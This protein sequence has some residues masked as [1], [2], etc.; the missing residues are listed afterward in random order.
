MQP[1]KYDVV[2]V[3]S[4]LGG[5]GAG[6][7]LSHWGYQTLM[8][9]K[10]DTI[11][12][13]WANYKYEGF[14]I[15]AGALAILYHGTEM[16]EIFNEVGAEAEVIRVPRVYYRIGGKDWE[17][18]AKGAIGAMFNIIE[19][20]DQERANKEGTPRT[21]DSEKVTNA[22][23]EGIQE[24][25]KIGWLT[26][27]DWLHQYTDNE[28]AH[29]MF[30]T[31]SNTI[32][33]AHSYEVQAAA[34]FSFLVKSRGFRDVSIAP[35]G[36]MANVENLA[37]VVRANGNVWINCPAKRII[38]SGGTAKGVVVEKDGSELEIASQV[39]ISNAG[40]RKTVEL[41]GAENFGE[42]YLSRM[43]VRLKP[44]PVIMC[45]IASDRPIWPESGEPA[46]LM[47]VGARRITSVVPLSNISP[48]FAP[49]GQY[50]TFCFG[51]PVSNEIHMNAE[52]EQEQCL[53]DIKEQ[54][55][56][57]EKHGKILKMIPKDIDD[58]LPEMH[59]RIGSGMPTETPIRNLYNVGDGCETY[60]YS[61]SNLAA[62]SAKPVAETIKNSIKPGKA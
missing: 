4:G 15:P 46:Y 26:L 37:K 45:F 51:G 49:P 39:V 43:R 48:H 62:G 55:P 24:R 31:I 50:L 33:G 13:R 28:M 47:V 58:D 27:K 38:V 21:M 52:A 29:G 6:S 32:C 11:G 44:H 7:L 14:N 35:K 20:L 19:K 59:T 53:L 9:E 5:L 42:E 41:A 23:R 16:E 30:D 61:G 1:Q 18:P 22:F 40:P 3:G 57:F 10:L 2:V 54:F 60:G 56:L 25:D 36:N 17:M 8:V 34:F 12:G